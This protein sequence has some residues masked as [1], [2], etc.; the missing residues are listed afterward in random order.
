[1]SFGFANANGLEDIYDLSSRWNI[2]VEAK[3]SFWNFWGSKKYDIIPHGENTGLLHTHN[4]APNFSWRRQFTP[5]GRRM[6]PC[7]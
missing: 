2:E 1:M 4:E 7:D 6:G 5:I 3:S